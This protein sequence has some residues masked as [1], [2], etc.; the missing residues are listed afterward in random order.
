MGK[1]LEKLLDLDNLAF[2][3]VD[4]ARLLRNQAKP[5]VVGSPEYAAYTSKADAFSEAASLIWSVL[6]R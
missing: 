1:K 2:E 3:F 5:E 4:K 6:D